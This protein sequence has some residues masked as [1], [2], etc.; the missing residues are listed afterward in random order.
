MGYPVG[1]LPLVMLPGELNMD[2]RLFLSIRIDPHVE[3]LISLSQ[4]LSLAAYNEISES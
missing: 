2:I 1:A 4:S 3:S